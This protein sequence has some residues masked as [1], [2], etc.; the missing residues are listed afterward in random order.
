[1]SHQLFK[2]CPWEWFSR[3]FSFYIF[4]FF[5]FEHPL[6]YIKVLHTHILITSLYYIRDWSLGNTF[7]I[8]SLGNVVFPQISMHILLKHTLSQTPS[9]SQV[10]HQLTKQVNKT[11]EIFSPFF[12]RQIPGPVDLGCKWR[13]AS[14]SPLCQFQTWTLAVGWVVVPELHQLLSWKEIWCDKEGQY[15]CIK[16]ESVYVHIYT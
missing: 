9:A 12:L 2:E 14:C 11:C 7:P 3:S 4:F 1:M 5:T 8:T 15:L 16:A 6:S 10:A 13:G